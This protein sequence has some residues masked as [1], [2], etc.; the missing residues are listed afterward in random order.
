MHDAINYSNEYKTVFIEYILSVLTSVTS[1]R[2]KNI[3][4]L[5]LEYF[6]Y[7]QYYSQDCTRVSY[8]ISG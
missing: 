6:S 7:I 5:D 2:K 3:S 8:F 4:G 1:S